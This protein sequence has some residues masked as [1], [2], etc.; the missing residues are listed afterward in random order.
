MVMGLLQCGEIEYA[1]VPGL[2]L[3]QV[4]GGAACCYFAGLMRPAVGELAAAL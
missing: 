3:F 2:F 4:P 1:R